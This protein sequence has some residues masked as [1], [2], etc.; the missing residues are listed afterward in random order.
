MCDI[1][2][3]RLSLLTTK[4]LTEKL[5]TQTPSIPDRFFCA[6]KT[7]LWAHIMRANGLEMITADM[8]GLEITD[9]MAWQN[10]LEAC[11][12]VD[13]KSKIPTFC[14]IVTVQGLGNEETEKQYGGIDEPGKKMILCRGSDWYENLYRGILKVRAAN[15]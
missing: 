7:L 2:K 12:Q 10:Y 14:G 13:S 3:L 5:Q 6:L 1:A 15:G 9:D 4:M 8:L 11:K